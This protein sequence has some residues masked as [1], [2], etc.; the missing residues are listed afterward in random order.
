MEKKTLKK[1]AIIFEPSGRRGLI[2]DGSTIMEAAQALGVD[3]QNVCGGQAQ[4]GKCKVRVIEGGRGH[5]GVASGGEN[6]SPAGENEKNIL[7]ETALSEGWRLAC[8]ACVHGDVVLNVPKESQ[9]RGQIIAKMPGK[10]DITTKPAAKK[11]AVTLNPADLD[12]PRADWER[13]KAVLK[14]DHG[15]DHLRPDYAVLRNLQD[16]IRQG[17][18]QLTV[19]VWMDEEVIHVEPGLVE[20]AYGLA[21]DIGTTTVAAYLCE[22]ESGKVLATASM[23]NPQVVYGEDVI[24]RISHAMTQPQG[25]NTLHETIVQGINQ[26]IGDV[27]KKAGIAPRDILD[28]AVVGN[29]C[30]H[31]LF[32]GFNPE[33]LGKSPFVPAVHHGLDVKARDLNLKTAP[34]GYVHVLPVVAGFVG[35]DTVGVMLAEEPY[36]R[37]ETVLIMDVGTNGELILGNRDRLVCA[38]CATGPA[39]EGATIRHGMRAAVGAI[40][41]IRIDPES[42]EV[43]LSLIRKDPPSRK[44]EALK[45]MG[46][47]GSGIIDGIAQMFSAGIVD[48]SGRII[49]DLNTARVMTGEDGR[50]FVLAWSRETQTNREIVIT[51]GDVRAIQ[52]AKGALYAGAKL[53]MEKLGTPKVD[54]VIL[55][56]AFG[57]FIDRQSASIIGM[58]PD[59]P[60]EQV[61]AVGNAAGD[62]ARIAL[63]NVDKRREAE[64]EAR[65]IAYLELTTVPDFQMEFVYA[66]HFPHMTDTFRHRP[67]HQ[68]PS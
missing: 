44:G 40:E 8:Q 39:F 9:A 10:K 14:R 1:H 49:N 7:S 46:I 26:M 21:V 36:R 22:L 15:L 25:L 30:M 34:G 51:Q 33:Y 12:D 50:A 11:Y 19:S 57:S 60:L 6:L 47:C 68:T 58:F 42:K 20:K 3:I 66:M 32:L 24:S 53:M 31:H 64:R 17:N 27:S 23:V 2:E 63:L 16:L 29:T 18:W 35:A 54:K 56:G 43:S 37:E 38:S 61:E 55:A 52:M 67:I 62:G 48:K 4:C 59:C 5:H 41:G 28:M 13:L 45:A 65:K